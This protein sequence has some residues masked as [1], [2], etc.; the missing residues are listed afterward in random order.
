MQSENLLGAR[1]HGKSRNIPI[2]VERILINTHFMKKLLGLIAILLI[3]TP[4]WSMIDKNDAPLDYGYV[5]TLPSADVIAPTLDVAVD[6]PSDTLVALVPKLKNPESA[7]ADLYLNDDDVGWNDSLLYS[8]LTK[9][10]GTDSKDLP[11]L[12]PLRNDLA[13]TLE[14]NDANGLKD[15]PLLVPLK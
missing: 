15:L 5:Y 6:L 14:I 4:S 3:C 10:V 8:T 11:L 9:S 13:Y 1:G 2:E 12:V 7:L